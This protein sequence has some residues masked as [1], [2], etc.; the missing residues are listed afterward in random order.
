MFFISIG[1]AIFLLGVAILTLRRWDKE[2]TLEPP[3]K[4]PGSRRRCDYQ[5]I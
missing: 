1:E 2:K 3:Y 4:T 5:N